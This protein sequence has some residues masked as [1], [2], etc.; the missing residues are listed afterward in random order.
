MKMV[1]LMLTIW[2]AQQALDSEDGGFSGTACNDGIDND[3]HG[4]VDSEDPH[5]LNT[6]SRQR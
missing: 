2:T 6:W 1:G 5:C 3:G 4:D